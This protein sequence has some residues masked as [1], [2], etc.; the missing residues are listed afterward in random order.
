[1][2]EPSRTTESSLD[3]QRTQ[4]LDWLR[5]AWRDPQFLAERPPSE[6]RRHHEIIA[7]R[8]LDH[9]RISG[10][11]CQ[12]IEIAVSGHPAFEVR[13]TH[14]G[15]HFVGFK[16]PPPAANSADALLTGCAALLENEWCRARLPD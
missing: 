6:L 12:V 9:A 11:E 5:A 7:Q 3:Q 4:V 1:M 15:S 8:F 16:Q 10:F 14:R 2:N 13:W